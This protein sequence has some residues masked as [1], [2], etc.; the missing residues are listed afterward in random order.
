MDKSSSVII[1]Y[2]TGIII[3][4]LFL[5]LWSAETTILKGLIGLIW[6]ALFLIALFFSEKNNN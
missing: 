5:N 6:T 4:A 3:G 2:I 1:I